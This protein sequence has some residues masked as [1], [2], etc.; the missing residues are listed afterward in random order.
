MN[1]ERIEQ[2]IAVFDFAL[3]HEEVEQLSQFDKDY[4][5]R[6]NTYVKF[7]RHPHFPFPKK[8]ATDAEIQHAIDSIVEDWFISNVFVPSYFLW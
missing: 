3:T 5:L 8:N 7:Y 1:K 6:T 2:N 4:R